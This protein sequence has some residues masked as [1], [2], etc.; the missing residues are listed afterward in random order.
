MTARAKRAS[1]SS[2]R[3]RRHVQELVS[4]CSGPRKLRREEAARD[5]EETSAR[6]RPIFDMEQRKRRRQ[7]RVRPS[8]EKLCALVQTLRC[9]FEVGSATARRREVEAGSARG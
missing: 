3:P 5:Q 2:E 6:Q 7:I 9:S 4:R 8:V 1:L